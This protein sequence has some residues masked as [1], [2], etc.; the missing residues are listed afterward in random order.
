M[1]DGGSFENALRTREFEPDC[2]N[3]TPRISAAADNKTGVFKM[4]ILKSDKGNNSQCLRY[5]YE[6]LSPVNGEGRF[7]HKY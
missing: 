1:R 3:Y 5:L 4:S 2:P 6:Y 7:I